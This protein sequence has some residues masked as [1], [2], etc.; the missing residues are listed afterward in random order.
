MSKFIPLIDKIAE[1][2]ESG[3]VAAFNRYYTEAT[4][5]EYAPD[6]Y[7]VAQL[8]E[9]TF[10]MAKRKYG[11]GSYWGTKRRRIK[12]KRAKIRARRKIGEP[13]GLSTAKYNLCVNYF[14][15]LRDSNTLHNDNINLLLRGDEI[16]QRERNIINLRGWKID[17][18]IFNQ[19]A[20][21]QIVNVAILQNTNNDGGPQ[22][23]NFF[24][25]EGDTTERAV[26][27]DSTISVLKWAHGI[28]N[29]ELYNVL[30][31]KRFMIGPNALFSDFD[32]G[33]VMHSWKNFKR[34]VPLK[35]Q[36]S[37]DTAGNEP[38]SNDVHICW[39]TTLIKNQVT[40]GVSTPT[41]NAVLFNMQV[42]QVF[43]DPKP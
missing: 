34:Y 20:S 3:P 17:M 13:I 19:T 14:G 33:A 23:S 4:L 41:V 18:T 43:R 21:P 9:D 12:G 42:R 25:A 29:R 15:S 8:R 2:A 37:Y 32:S 24:K 40:P 36:I 6:E 31:H 35:R 39:W 7:F 16:N 1:V 5:G 11:G 26:D 27:A 10:N 30:M 38:M 28:I 22:N